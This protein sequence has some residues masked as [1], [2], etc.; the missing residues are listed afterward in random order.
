MLVV[1]SCGEK[2]Q[3]IVKNYDEI[4]IVYKKTAY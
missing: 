4:L 1:D 3:F 2:Q